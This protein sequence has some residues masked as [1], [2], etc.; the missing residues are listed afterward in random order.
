MCLPMLP[1][2]ELGHYHQ[3][4]PQSNYAHVQHH[5]HPD[6]N[7]TPRPNC[8][9]VDLGELNSASMQPIRERSVPSLLEYW[10]GCMALVSLR[11]AL[12]KYP[13]EELA[14]QGCCSTLN[15]LFNSTLSEHSS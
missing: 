12:M 13:R 4:S 1:C 11:E 9:I 8:S 6:A 14:Q 5:P 10:I 3:G 2:S 7:A 15:L